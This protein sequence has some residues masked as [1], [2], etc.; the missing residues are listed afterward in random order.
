MGMG[1]TVVFFVAVS[2]S[3][4]LATYANPLSHHV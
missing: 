2:S 1:G 3:L 4:T